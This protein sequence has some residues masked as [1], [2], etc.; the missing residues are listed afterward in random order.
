MLNFLAA[1]CWLW[2]RVGW[3]D[4]FWP[5]NC[6]VCKCVPGQVYLLSPVHVM[7]R[8]CQR[9]QSA[10]ITVDHLVLTN[11]DFV[12]DLSLWRMLPSQ[13]IKLYRIMAAFRVKM[14]LSQQSVSLGAEWVDVWP[15][16]RVCFFHRSS[17]SNKVPRY[18]LLLS[19]QTAVK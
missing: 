7:V 17:Y 8:R 16:L 6:K 4:L 14:Y 9:W 18:Q 13:C 1:S 3:C 2:R 10:E 19:M 12:N 11:K 5:L 15:F